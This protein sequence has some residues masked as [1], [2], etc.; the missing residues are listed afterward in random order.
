MTFWQVDREMVLL[1][2]GGR[3][4]LM[5][6][7]HPKIAAGVADHSHFKEDPLGRLYRT[8]N[9]MWSVSFGEKSEARLALEQVK[10][11]HRRVHGEIKP[12]E[13]L[14]AGTPYDAFDE[15]LL[16]WVHATLI[17][18]AMVGYDF[19]VRPLTQPEKS[20]YYEDSKRLAALFEIP[21][22]IVPSSLEEF[23][24][25]ME[26]MLTG[27]TI[28]VGPTALSLAQEIIRPHPWILKPGVPLHRLFTA[29]LLPERL[30]RDYKIP[31]NE[32][33]EKTFLLLAKAIRGLLPLAPNFL[34][35]VPH[36]RAAEKSL[37][38]A[39]IV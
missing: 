28:A 8:M 23:K 10:N 26:Q 4:L 31:W 6:L 17:D 11:V 37:R 35:I 2:A 5:Q 16:L 34:R 30:R 38:R 19:F 15:E 39:Q 13:P 9:T 7:A 21:A 18:A 25:Y 12:V 29:G 20:R 27:N 32:R 1:L 33:R 22:E 36:A 24:K 3:A 14:P